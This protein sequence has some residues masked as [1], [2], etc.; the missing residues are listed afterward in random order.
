MQAFLRFL[1][2]PLS[3][4]FFLYTCPTSV[5]TLYVQFLNRHIFGF[6]FFFHLFVQ[7]VHVW[8]I[9]GEFSACKEA[10]SWDSDIFFTETTKKV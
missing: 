2:V 5:F 7:I 3:F 4:V 9:E 8:R 1:H 6:G 10:W